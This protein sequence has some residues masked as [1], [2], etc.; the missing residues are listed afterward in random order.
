M[1]GVDRA[2]AKLCCT[3]PMTAGRF[4][5]NGRVR[6]GAHTKPILLVGPGCKPLPAATLEDKFKSRDR[7]GP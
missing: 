5:A 6:L 3:G 2:S 4:E 1:P 7:A